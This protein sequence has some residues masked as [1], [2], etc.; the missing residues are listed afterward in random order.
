[1]RGL[2]GHPTRSR[3]G[4]KGYRA[5]LVNFGAALRGESQ[6]AVTAQDGLRATYIAEKA[7]EAIRTNRVIDLQAGD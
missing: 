4:E 6:L 2:P 1:M 5:Q 3:A 7:L